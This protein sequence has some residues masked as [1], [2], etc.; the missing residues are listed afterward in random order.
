MADDPDQADQQP[1]GWAMAGI[2]FAAAVLMLIG[3][4]QVIAG[5]TAIFNKGNA[6]CT[7]ALRPAPSHARVPAIPTTVRER[8]S[9]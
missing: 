4:F 7:Y 2:T 1:S 6:V 8:C 5:L 3:F 9:P